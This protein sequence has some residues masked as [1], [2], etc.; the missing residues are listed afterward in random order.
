MIKREGLMIEF[1]SV[2]DCVFFLVSFVN[3]GF[4]KLLIYLLV[5][6]SEYLLAGEKSD[7]TSLNGAVNSQTGGHLI[8]D[9]MF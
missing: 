2:F 9:E 7:K 3:T 1:W 5:T 8:T 6:N 4:A